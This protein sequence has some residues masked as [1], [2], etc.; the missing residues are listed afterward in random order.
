M[1]CA[2]NP[3]AHTGPCVAE[4]RAAAVDAR[5]PAS[6]RSLATRSLR[7]ASRTTRSPATST[8]PARAV[9]RSDAASGRHRR[10]LMTL[11]SGCSTTDDRL[12]VWGYISPGIFQPTCASSSCHSRAA[13][14]AGSGP[15]RSG[16]RLRQ[17]HR[18][19]RLGADAVRRSRGRLQGDRWDDLLPACAPARRPL[20]P[21]AVT[22]RHHAPRAERARAC[23]R[24]DRC[25]KLTSRWSSAGSS[26]APAKVNFDALRRRRRPRAAT[27]AERAGAH[28]RRRR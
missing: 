28:Q 8:S 10:F 18:G 15:L 13:A 7:S 6:S 27:R 9:R 12:F 25:R 5:P 23:H 20:Q 22:P 16:S 26:T 11:A 4:Y 3:K 17:P 1:T 2:R 19:D 21:D 24:I 14:V